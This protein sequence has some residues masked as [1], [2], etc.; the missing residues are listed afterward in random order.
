MKQSEELAQQILAVVAL[1]PHGKVA[2]Y[3]QIAKLAGLPRHA[4][5][6]GK[7]LQNLD[8][9]SQLTWHRVVNAQGK[10]STCHVNTQGQNIQKIKLEAEDIK[11]VTDKINLKIYQWQP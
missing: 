1:I 8:E 6:V 11:F 10:I 4:R 5:M 2:S 9:T 3:G 7:V